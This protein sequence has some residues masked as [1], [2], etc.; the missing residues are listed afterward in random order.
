MPAL[1][2]LGLL[3]AL[4]KL[5]IDISVYLKDHPQL[6]AQAKQVL[7]NVH[8]DMSAMHHDLR[9]ERGRIPEAP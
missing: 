1:A 8:E 2:L 4:I 5:A 6:P 9:E 3:L 7:A